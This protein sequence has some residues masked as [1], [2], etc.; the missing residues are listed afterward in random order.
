MYGLVNI[1]GSC[2]LNTVAQIL[3]HIPSFKESLK[4]Y[5]GDNIQA[6][7]LKA[8]SENLYKNTSSAIDLRNSLKIPP[9]AEDAG[10]SLALL[11]D[12]LP[13]ELTKEFQTQLIDGTN[14]FTDKSSSENINCLIFTNIINPTN[15]T[16][17]IDTLFSYK[18][19]RFP[20]VLI[21]DTGDTG[22]I[23]HYNIPFEFNDYKLISLGIYTGGHY[24]ALCKIDDKWYKYNDSNVFLVRN[25]EI[26]PGTIP[27][28][29][30]Y[31]KSIH[32]D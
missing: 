27:K 25:I 1:G 16:N 19:M 30:V 32:M 21:I 15:E 31:E 2:Y 4:Q 22:T 5:T 23:C 9:G 3:V 28:I 18:L 24:Y 14:T 29:I 12:S 26:P 10:N 17:F 20:E 11:L 13:N 8:L 7:T 6:K